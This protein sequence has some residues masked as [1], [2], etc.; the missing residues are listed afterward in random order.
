MLGYLEQAAGQDHLEALY[1][2][3]TLYYDSEVV[4][5]DLNR[6]RDYFQ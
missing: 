2:L 1:Y 6:A 3:G 4:P 5:Q